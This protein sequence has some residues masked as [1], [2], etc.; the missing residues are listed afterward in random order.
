MEQDRESPSYAKLAVESE[1]GEGAE[2]MTR[3][4]RKRV[5][6]ERGRNGGKGGRGRTAET[7]LELTVRINLY[8]FAR[9]RV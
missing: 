1:R 7:T 5:R 9:I 4:Q 2:G 8:G 6:K 3:I